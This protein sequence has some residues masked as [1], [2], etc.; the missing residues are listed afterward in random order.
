LIYSLF[1]L[2]P[3]GASDPP[4]GV[5]TPGYRLKPAKAG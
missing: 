4:P 5:K 1:N 2:N 3:I